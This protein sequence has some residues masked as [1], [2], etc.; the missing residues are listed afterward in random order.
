MLASRL[1][2]VE[3][4]TGRVAKRTAKDHDPAIPRTQGAEAALYPQVARWAR[5]RLGCWEVALDTGPKMGRIDVVGLRDM[6]AIDL[7]A[8]TEVL[9]I[10]VKVGTASFA[11]SAGQALGYSVMA[12]RC[13][14]AVAGTFDEDA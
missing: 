4:T 5:K 1:D 11:K 7:A 8:R 9:A 13:Y 14:L 12:D 2:S 6:G 10:E 3:R